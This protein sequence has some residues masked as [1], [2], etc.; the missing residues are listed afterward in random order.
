MTLSLLVIDDDDT[1]RST[2]VEFFETFGFTARG[3]STATEGR[4]LAAEHAP[5]VVL[6]D[7]RLPDADGVRVLEALRADDPDLAVIVLTGYA[8]VR[9]AV[10]AMQ[11]GAADLLE[12]KFLISFALTE[13]LGILAFLVSAYLVFA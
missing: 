11:H 6:L 5:D 8:D 4:Q 1:V 13:A 10:A 9:T 7:L 2:L 3:A 12:K